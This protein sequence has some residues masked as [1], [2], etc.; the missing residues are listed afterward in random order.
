MGTILTV[1]FNEGEVLEQ[2][3]Q[4][5]VSALKNDDVPELWRLTEDLLELALMSAHKQ[6]KSHWP[7][8]YVSETRLF[9]VPLDLVRDMPHL[10]CDQ[11]VIYPYVVRK[12]VELAH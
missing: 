11:Y 3:F 6:S 8:G 10:L 7:M 9:N 4:L 12:T 1:T 5:K 2:L